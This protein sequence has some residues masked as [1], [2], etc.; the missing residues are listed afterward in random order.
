MGNECLNKINVYINIYIGAVTPEKF[1]KNF[2]TSKNFR[3]NIKN[4]YPLLG[5]AKN[6]CRA[7]KFS[8]FG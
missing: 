6:L 2:R 3:N 8:S 7:F 4:L 5:A 1:S